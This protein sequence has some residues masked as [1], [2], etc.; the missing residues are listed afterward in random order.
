MK[1][2]N[3]FLAA[4]LP[5]VAFA[6]VI[7][8]R[9]PKTARDKTTQATDLCQNALLDF[10]GTF[11]SDFSYLSSKKIRDAQDSTV[12]SIRENVEAPMGG[13]PV[14]GTS[15]DSLHTIGLSTCLAVGVTIPDVAAG[16]TDK[17]LAHI[18]MGLKAET[19]VSQTK[20]I[21]KAVDAALKAAKAAAPARTIQPTYYV[22]LS[23]LESQVEDM[24][25]SPTLAGKSAEYKAD[26]RTGLT[27]KQTAFENFV[28]RF[29]KWMNAQTGGAEATHVKTRKRN[30]G[31]GSVPD[32]TLK[33]LQDGRVESEGIAWA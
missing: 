13:P 14:S 2:S 7:F 33:I 24:L 11:P 4:F 10:H 17:L 18:S 8:E 27:Q 19:P 16:K 20:E 29:V 32:G 31:M 3:F 30:P 26:A 15:S 6:G 12:L 25:N 5:G 22:S 23:H 21:W 28:I 1:L 9:D